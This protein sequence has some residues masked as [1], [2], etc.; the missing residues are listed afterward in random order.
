MRFRLE[1]VLERRLHL[2]LAEKNMAEQEMAISRARV[3]LQVLA[4]GMVGLRELG[5]LEKR[6]GVREKRFGLV[7]GLSRGVSLC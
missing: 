2:N 4:R 7:G 3:A 5:V 6:F 1:L